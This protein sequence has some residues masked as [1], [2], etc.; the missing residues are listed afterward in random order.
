[1]KNFVIFGLLL[2]GLLVGGGCAS[3]YQGVYPNGNYYYSIGSPPLGGGYK[4]STYI[5]FVNSTRDVKIK[6]SSYGLELSP[7]L[8]PGQTLTYYNFLAFRYEQVSFIIQCY[9]M[10]LSR[11]VENI[12][13]DTATMNM[14]WGVASNILTFYGSEYEGVESR[15]DGP[16]FRRGGGLRGCGGYGRFGY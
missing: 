3:I 10:S 9:D 14:Y 11:L 7:P 8:S 13:S 1:M 4:S 2:V 6:I 16:S 12:L 5:T 15:K